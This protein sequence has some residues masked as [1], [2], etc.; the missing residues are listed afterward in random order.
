MKIVNPELFAIFLFSDLIIIV[1]NK[2]EYQKN[3]KPVGLAVAVV[4]CYLDEVWLIDW[5][6]DSGVEDLQA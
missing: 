2:L 1:I 6:I 3:W 4:K 5:L